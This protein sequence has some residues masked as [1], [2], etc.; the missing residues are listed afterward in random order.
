MA[1]W[2]MK[3][4]RNGYSARCFGKDKITNAKQLQCATGFRVVMVVVVA[5]RTSPPGTSTNY[6]CYDASLRVRLP[7][8]CSTTP[9]GAI[10][11]DS[12]CLSRVTGQSLLTVQL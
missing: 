6:L 10:Q 9:S 5:A 12:L 8:C 4:S 1:D 11:N 7:N 2:V 3:T